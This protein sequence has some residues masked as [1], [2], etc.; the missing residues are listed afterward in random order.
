MRKGVIKNN[1]SKEKQKNIKEN[2]NKS[3]EKKT[4]K[5]NK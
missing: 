5:E 4:N 3:K 2:Y 1:K